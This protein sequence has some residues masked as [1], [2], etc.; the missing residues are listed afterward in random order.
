MAVTTRLTWL[1][2]NILQ[3]HFGGKRLSLLY[4]G[5]V[6][7]FCSGDL[8]D[9]CCNQGPTL[10]VIYGEHHIIGAYAEDS[11]QERKSASIILFALQET[12]ISEWKLGLCTPERL[13]CYDN[14]QY[15]STTN[16]QIEL[17]NRKVIMGSK[18]TEDL[19]LV[20]NCT[21]SIQDCEVF[22]CEDLL[23][24]R[25]IKGATELRKSLLSALRT[26]EPYGSLVPQIRILL[27]GPVGAGKSS[28]F[29][30]VRSVFQGHVTHQALV[31]TNRTGI[32]EKYRTY[33]IRDGKDGKYLPFILC[34]SLGLGE[35]EGGLCR[36]DILYILNGNIRDRYQF[37][38]MESI[39]LGHRDYIDSP[40][41]K[42]RIHCVAFVFDTNSVEHF[43][44]Q[45]IVKIKRL[46]R[47]L[48]NAGVVHVALLT[49]VDSMDLIT[50]GD[51]IEIDRCVPLRSKL[52]EF[53]RKLGF[54]LSDVSVVSNYSSEWEL[55]PVK[56]VLILSALR[57][58]L[59]AADDFLEDLPLEE[60]GIKERKLSSVHKEEN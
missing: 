6:H 10:T 32:S 7:G 28:F 13:F 21:I 49:H 59:W 52:E 56:D 42:D 23:D 5:S 55:D 2:E 45:M 51:L 41:L 58:M 33:S 27:L 38:P 18:T 29:N 17:R 11:Y 54:A 24:E 8:L 31:G 47:E 12:K 26:Y 43:S 15:N 40:S 19:G 53:Q 3:N 30:S 37:N 48:I 50:K 20:Q 39:K 25:K 9:R 4:K 44:S 16:F 57:R 34:D 22:R 35:K 14:I 36:D 1:H 46:R 60:E